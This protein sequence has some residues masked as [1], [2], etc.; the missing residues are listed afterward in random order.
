MRADVRS[1]LVAVAAIFAQSWYA[2]EAKPLHAGLDYHRYLQERD[3]VAERLEQWRK[4]APGQEAAKNNWGFDGESRSGE[5]AEDQLQRFAMTEQLIEKVRALN[6]EAN[7]STSSPFTLMTDE[8]FNKY[9]GQSF[10]A[11]EALM[12]EATANMTEH[13]FEADRDGETSID[14]SQSGCVGRVKDQ[15]QCGSCYAFGTVAAAESAYC[16]RNNRQ[17][18]HFSDQQ[19]TSCSEHGC[20]GGWPQNSLNYIMRNGLCTEN[21]Y[22]YRSGTTKQ[23]GQCQA[24]QCQ[25][26]NLNIRQIVHVR[27]S[28]QALENAVRGRP[29]SVGLAAGNSAWKQYKG[30]V[31]STCT[32][33]QLDHVVLVYGFT[34]EYWMVKNSWGTSW[35]ENGFLK[36]KRGVSH[37]GSWGGGGW[38][39]MGGGGSNGLCGMYSLMTYPDI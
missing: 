20:Q 3:Q 31:L 19:V 9:V 7:F 34:P 29:V 33:T 21:A 28:E 14:W 30:G 32:S 12:N 23:P 5:A 26:V 11:G 38:G 8:E 17:L 25:H 37:R 36:M 16:I 18:V 6:P 13:K 15:G 24:N 22:S 10:A 1:S 27:Q 2:V 39:G 35:G 4:S